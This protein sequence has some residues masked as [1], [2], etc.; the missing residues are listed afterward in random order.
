MITPLPKIYDW[1]QT[2]EDPVVAREDPSVPTHLQTVGK[3]INYDQ[4]D[5]AV[6]SMAD[7]LNEQVYAPLNEWLKVYR[8]VQVR[9]GRQLPSHVC[10]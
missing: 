8:E 9:A 4:L 3:I 6:K 5:A 7:Q 1:G 10:M 2:T